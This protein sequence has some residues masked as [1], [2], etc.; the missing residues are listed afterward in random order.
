MPTP[1][2]KVRIDRFRIA[3]NKLKR[4]ADAGLEKLKSDTDLIDIAEK[5][6]QI[7][8]EVIIENW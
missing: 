7:S 2:V 8:I 6:L 3:I 1:G 4:I 5:N